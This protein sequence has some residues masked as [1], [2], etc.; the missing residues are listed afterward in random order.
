[1]ARPS[2][3]TRSKDSSDDVVDSS[4]VDRG[5]RAQ[6]TLQVDS[7]AQHHLDRHVGTGNVGE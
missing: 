4:K 1:M 2:Q 7:R 5:G 6:T 3:P